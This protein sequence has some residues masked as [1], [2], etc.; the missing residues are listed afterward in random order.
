MEKTKLSHIVAAH[1][2]INE[3]IAML[4]INFPNL[5]K[6]NMFKNWL[7]KYAMQLAKKNGKENEN[8][9]LI[10]FCR[11]IHELLIIACGVKIH[12]CMIIANNR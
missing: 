4:L 12:N 10:S 6:T 1:I 2:D 8:I 9:M 5:S 3:L 11:F 7:V